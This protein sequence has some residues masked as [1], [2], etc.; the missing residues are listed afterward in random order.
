[1]S[2][3]CGIC[4]EII[5][6]CDDNLVRLEC[7][8]FLCRECYDRLQKQSCPFC[9]TPFDGADSSADDTDEEDEIPSPPLP[10]SNRSAPVDIPV[11]SSYPPRSRIRR[12]QRAVILQENVS[13]ISN[14]L[15]RRELWEWNSVDMNSWQLNRL[16]KQK[17]RHRHLIQVS[18]EI[19]EAPFEC[20]D[21]FDEIAL[22]YISV[23]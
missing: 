16:L 19:L 15:G 10:F 22:Y 1:M 3:E 12:R 6:D 13:R 14:N 21:E 11:S 17:T 7:A 8:H 2:N 23:D 18:R 4:Y 9:R 5:T 20:Q